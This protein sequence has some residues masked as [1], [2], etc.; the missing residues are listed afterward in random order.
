M[1]RGL[2][3]CLSAAGFMAAASF[4][5]ERLSSTTWFFSFLTLSV[6]FVVMGY[7]W[8][9]SSPPSGKDRT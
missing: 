5:C 6:I 3:T 4:S 8:L 2:V 1:S 7:S 9:R